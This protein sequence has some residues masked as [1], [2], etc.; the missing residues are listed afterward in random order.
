M[1]S[2]YVTKLCCYYI[3]YFINTAITLFKKYCDEFL[4][5]LPADCLVTLDKL[6]KGNIAFTNEAFGYVLS[7]SS[8]KE[9]N[10]EILYFSIASTR[11]DNQLLG[12]SYIMQMLT[13]ECN[14]AALFRDGEC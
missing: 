14:V 4:E 3:Y 1:H 7:C 11:N 2:M 10:K 12:F 9:F 6:A 5:N 13:E 8:S